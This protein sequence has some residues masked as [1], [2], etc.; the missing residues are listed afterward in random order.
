MG[1]SSGL[2]ILRMQLARQ[3][4]TLNLDSDHTVPSD[5]DFADVVFMSLID[6][7]TKPHQECDA[8]H[9]LCGSFNVNVPE[10]VNGVFCLLLQ[11]LNTVTERDPEVLTRTGF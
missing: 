11:N 4:P 6:M 5:W 10:N 2:Y 8:I 1:P 3:C 9:K 7:C